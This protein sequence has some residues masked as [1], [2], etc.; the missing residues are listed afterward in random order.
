MR[1]K[2]ESRLRCPKVYRKGS[3]YVI[4][5]RVPGNLLIQVKVWSALEKVEKR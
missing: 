5:L 1:Q 3:R 2:W 4:M